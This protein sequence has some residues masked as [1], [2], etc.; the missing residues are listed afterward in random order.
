MKVDE[1]LREKRGF[2][3]L[4]IRRKRFCNKT[5][6]NTK[7]RGT[8]KSRRAQGRAIRVSGSSRFLAGGPMQRSSAQKMEMYVEDGLTGA[9][10][11]VV[12]RS[13]STFDSAVGGQLWRP[14]VHV[15]QEI[16]IRSL[17]LF[18]S[19]DMLFGNN[20]DV[21]GRLR[22]DVLEGKCF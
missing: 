6:S 18:Q 14:Q 15:T 12:N 20:Q 17:E 11:N 4:L 21:C 2:S 1:N 16:K 19:P 13:V 3:K 7:T 5:K 9:G 22:L 10:P 8:E